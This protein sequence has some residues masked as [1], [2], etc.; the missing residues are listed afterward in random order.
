MEPSSIIAWN[1]ISLRVPQTWEPSVLERDFMR[2]EEHG[3]P[4]AEAKWSRVSGSFSVERHIRKLKRRFRGADIRV[5]SPGPEWDESAELLRQGG[6]QTTILQWESVVAAIIHSSSTGLSLLLQFLKTNEMSPA[7]LASVRDHWAGKSL[8]WSLFGLRAR[9][10]SEYLL[11]T[12]S[13]KPGHYSLRFRRPK[14]N[15]AIDAKPQDLRRGPG[16]ELTLER[17]APADV[18]LAKQSFLGWAKEN[19]RKAI[20]G[21]KI[22]D[23][24]VLSWIFFQKRFLRKEICHQGRVWQDS[25]AN[26]IFSVVSKGS[27]SLSESEFLRICDEY[28]AV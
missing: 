3:L 1:G 11:D 25:R 27:L 5:A 15:L 18:M 6:L 19:Y 23:D 22:F 28:G 2:L 12:F 21:E 24:N 13:F 20:V 7:T 8:P 4:V 9:I 10:P 17:Y 14:R 16:A 26:S